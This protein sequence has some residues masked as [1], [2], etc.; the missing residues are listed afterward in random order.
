MMNVV[1]YQWV[2]FGVFGYG[3]MPVLS[4][5]KIFSESGVSTSWV[6]N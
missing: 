4:Y 2:C 6:D 3:I 1:G 5:C